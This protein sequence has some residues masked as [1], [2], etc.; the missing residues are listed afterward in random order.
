M[1]TAA[2]FILSTFLGAVTRRVQLNLVGKPASKSWNGLTGYALSISAFVGGYLVSDHF[3]ERNRALLGRR[4]SQL[5]EQRAKAAEFHEFDLEA[6]HR[7]T[8]AKRESKFFDLLNKYGK[9]YK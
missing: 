6:D 9:E 5:R 4:L 8:A 7:I 2:G 3:I 1:P